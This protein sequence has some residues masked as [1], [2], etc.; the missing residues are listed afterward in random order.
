[1]PETYVA[2]GLCGC[3]D[4]DILHT[5]DDS[6][7]VKCRWCGLVY[8]DPR[9]SS[10]QV[11]RLYVESYFRSPDPL[12]F[13]YGDYAAERAPLTRMFRAHL[14][15]IERRRRPG[16]ILDVGCA[17]GFFLALARDHGW[18]AC[19]VDVSA[20][21]ARLAREDLG[22]DVM[23]GTLEE[24]RKRRPGVD[25]SFDV[26]TMWGLVEHLSD[27][28]SDLQQARAVL[29]DGGLLFLTVPNAGSVTARLLGKRWYG[30]RKVKEHFF[31]F[32][33]DTMSKMLAKAGFEVIEVRRAILS[34]SV[35]F[36]VDKLEQYSRVLQR[37][38]DWI[39][40]TARLR[41]KTFNFRFLDM[42]VVA[43]KPAS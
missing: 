28:L 35:G 26:V 7:I 42:L 24:M 38:L 19:G 17:L 6:T 11:R 4:A 14:A 36:F 41:Q 9:P 32:S 30:F 34:F 16:R 43:R 1:M 33:P 18:Q 10:Q 8:V 25:G 37:V 12:S 5:I 22:L 29:T 27:P 31:F 15:Q 13:G 40:S 2:C 21:A 20:Y 39:L 23:T 3:A